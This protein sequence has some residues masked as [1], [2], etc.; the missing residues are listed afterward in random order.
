MDGVLVRG[1]EEVKGICRRHFRTVIN[2][3]MERKFVVSSMGI[4]NI[5][6]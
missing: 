6:G 1:S 3:D 5:T 4:D 2:A